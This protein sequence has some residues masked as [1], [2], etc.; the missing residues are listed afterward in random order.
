MDSHQALHSDLRGSQ[1]FPALSS[2]LL[3]SP[4]ER[5]TSGRLLTTAAPSA[6]RLALER[7]NYGKGRG[8]A[9]KKN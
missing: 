1:I 8:L 3:L 5:S 7:Y 2:Q 6:Q 4:R 9:M